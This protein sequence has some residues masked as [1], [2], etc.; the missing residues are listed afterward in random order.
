MPIKIGEIADLWLG[1]N[2]T[3]HST[4]IFLLLCS[5]EDARNA[6]EVVP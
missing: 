3:I 2:G 1:L 4:T 6:T 5:K